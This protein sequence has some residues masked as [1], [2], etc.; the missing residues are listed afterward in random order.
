MKIPFLV[1][2]AVAAASGMLMAQAPA[3]QHAP[4]TQSGE[5]AKQTGS[6][7]LEDLEKTALQ[8]NPTLKQAEARVRAARG[9]MKQAGLY[10]NPIVGYEGDEISAGP[11]IRGSAAWARPASAGRGRRRPTQRTRR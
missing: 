3:L 7:R 8:N 9:K 5:K 6:L 1:T 10:P 11:V 4:Q 2:A